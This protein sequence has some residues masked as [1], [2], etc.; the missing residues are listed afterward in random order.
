MRPIRCFFP[1]QLFEIT[2]N[3]IN[4]ELLLRPSDEINAIILGVLGRAQAKT[5][6]RIHGFVVMSTHY[7]LLVTALNPKQLSKFMRLLNGGISRVL[8]KHH[9]RSGT[10][11]QRRFR[12]IGV[13]PDRQTQESRMQ[14]VLSHGVKENL[15]ANV[16]DWPGASSL[17]WLLH[18]KNISGV[19]T[20]YTAKYY[21]SRRKHYIPIE[22]E[23]DITYDVILTVMPCWK[24]MPP[25]EWRGR[26]AE[27]VAAVNHSHGS[28]GDGGAQPVLGAE[29]VLQA[30]PR[31]RIQRTKKTDA[32]K[33]HAV[34]PAVRDALS[35][36]V[37]AIR[38]AYA[39]ASAKFRAGDWRVEFPEGTFRPPGGY[40]PA[41][42]DTTA[43]AWETAWRA[44]A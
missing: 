26:V 32:P 41:S 29:A 31:S 7:H 19:W 12:A 14:Y 8:N 24:E 9:G 3:T 17:P 6:M 28:D 18:G 43:D 44:M 37:D 20:N 10:M 22:G 27:M 15:V 36:E 21:A 40:V 1:K 33:V 4:G 2:T 38:E 34:D 30:D 13:A 11:W 23:F 39:I 35:D 25:E 5:D 16:E 42:Q